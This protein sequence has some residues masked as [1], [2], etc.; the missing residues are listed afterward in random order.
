[1]WKYCD[2]ARRGA[3]ELRGF[4]QEGRKVRLRLR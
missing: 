3:G 4:L 2:S 1:M